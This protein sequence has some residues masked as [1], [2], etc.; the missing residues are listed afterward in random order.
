MT[1][2]AG[3][4]CQASS[5]EQLEGDS[6]N[7]TSRPRGPK[8]IPSSAHFVLPR[9]PMIRCISP[10]PAATHLT[11][12]AVAEP[13]DLLVGKAPACVWNQDQNQNQSPPA[14]AIIHTP[15][16]LAGYGRSEGRQKAAGP[17][18]FRPSNGVQSGD[19]GSTLCMEAGGLPAG[20]GPANGPSCHRPST[21]CT[22][23][24][25]AA[26]RRRSHICQLARA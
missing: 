4:R 17:S 3:G 10:I 25:I 24:P 5:H 12:R 2:V 16:G 6:S 7:S 18:R 9:P 26:A 14:N 23:S 15:G 8:H 19:A 1:D 20:A 13:A 22:C 11:R 21:G